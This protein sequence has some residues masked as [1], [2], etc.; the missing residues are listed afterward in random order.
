MYYFTWDN[1]A[2][3]TAPV[4]W[5]L[6]SARVA[7]DPYFKQPLEDCK[8]LT[9]QHLRCALALPSLPTGG[10]QAHGGEKRKG[11]PV[12]L[13]LSASAH[14]VGSPPVQFLC[15]HL[16]SCSCCEFCWK[17]VIKSVITFLSSHGA[18]GYSGRLFCD[19]LQ[20]FQPNIVNNHM[21]HTSTSI[22]L[23]L[24]ISKALLLSHFYKSKNSKR[25]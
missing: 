7:T 21:A 13:P 6:P 4:K 14:F 22:G 18:E 16:L 5:G 1:I 2:R 3:Q 17:L 11:S 10:W 12:F 25:K 23:N 9:L 20:C 19:P 8:K 15:S 24:N